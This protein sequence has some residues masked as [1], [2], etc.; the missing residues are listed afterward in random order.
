M[1]LLTAL[2]PCQNGL[3]IPKGTRIYG[4]IWS[5]AR[6]PEYFPDPETFDPLRWIDANGKLRD[7]MKSYPFG[8]GRRV[9]PGLHVAV[10]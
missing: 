7:D 10:A 8:F 4:N 2:I 9:C 3:C 1:V 6:D 5:I